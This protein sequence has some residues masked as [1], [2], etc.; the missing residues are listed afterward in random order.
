MRR[1]RIVA[2]L[3]AAIV[4]CAAALAGCSTA[5]RPAKT[6]PSPLSPA[7][8]GPGQPSPSGPGDGLGGEGP[9]AGAGG[10]PGTGPVGGVPGGPEGSASGGAVADSPPGTIT[11]ALLAAAISAGS[12]MSPGVVDGI[13]N[14]AQTADAP[15]G[16]AAERLKN[17]YAQ[18][19][20][21]KNKANE[22]DAVAAVSAAASDMSGVCADS[23]LRTAG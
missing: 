13:V 17:A 3:L 7:P 2:G 19:V 18:A 14:A 11:C 12:L 22:P 15:V 4:A 21:A 6:A 1:K 9:G 20:A 16:D 5:V 23:G 10:G 8:P